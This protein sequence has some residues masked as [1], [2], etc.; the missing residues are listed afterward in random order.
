LNIK[1]IFHP[2]NKRACVKVGLPD[3]PDQQ[4]YKL[5]K[6]WAIMTIACWRHFHM[7][8][9]WLAATSIQGTS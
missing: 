3:H 2:S 5:K 7:P 9:P 6:E 1:T 4:K 8:V